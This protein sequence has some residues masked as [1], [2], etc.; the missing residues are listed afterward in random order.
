MKERQE[1][2]KFEKYINI[3]QMQEHNKHII[4]SHVDPKLV[5]AGKIYNI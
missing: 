4:E 2:S 3:K 1:K 5:D